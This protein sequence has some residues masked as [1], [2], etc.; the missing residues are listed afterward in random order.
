VV[1]HKSQS[2]S[3]DTYP[4]QEVVPGDIR[5]PFKRLLARK[6]VGLFQL[7]ERQAIGIF[8]RSEK[9]LIIQVWIELAEESEPELAIR[10]G[11]CHNAV[12]SSW[13]PE[14]SPIPCGPDEVTTSN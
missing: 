5:V 10:R 6:N 14:D 3:E 2:A 9:S 11:E 13:T 8:N 1:R 4:L 7:R 12:K